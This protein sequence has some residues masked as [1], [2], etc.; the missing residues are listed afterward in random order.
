MVRFFLE[1][2]QHSVN[3]GTM[4]RAAKGS[5]S[6]FSRR[7]CLYTDI[8]GYT[9]SIKQQGLLTKHTRHPSTRVLCGKS[10]PLLSECGRVHRT[11]LLFPKAV[12]VALPHTWKEVVLLIEDAVA[13][14][15]L[16]VQLVCVPCR[17]FQNGV[18]RLSFKESGQLAETFREL[19]AI[20]S[21]TVAEEMVGE[22]S[23]CI[24]VT[25]MTQ[26]PRN[27]RWTTLSIYRYG[28][29][30]LLLKFCRMLTWDVR[31]LDLMIR[32][33]RSESRLQPAIRIID[34][35]LSQSTKG[36]G[37]SFVTSQWL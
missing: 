9:C 8:W 16:A 34:R 37:E 33:P 32:G 13:K 5:R 29:L 2:H 31:N 25:H 1:P 11:S 10:G 23:C 12:V 15:I 17:R 6:R 22:A 4:Y 26:G 30:P 21:V 20:L 7:I 27:P 3:R 28:G 36:A 19:T 14:Y 18:A 35:S 24:L